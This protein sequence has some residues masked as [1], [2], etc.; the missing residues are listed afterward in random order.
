MDLRCC[1]GELQKKCIGLHGRSLCLCEGL[2]LQCFPPLRACGRFIPR[3]SDWCLQQWRSWEKSFSPFEGGRWS[4]DQFT[5][6][7]HDVGLASAEHAMCISCLWQIHG[8][9]LSSWVKKKQLL[10]GNPNGQ[11]RVLV[12]PQAYTGE[13]AEVIFTMYLD[14]GGVE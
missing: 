1:P 12:G 10:G 3:C 7:I 5:D 14:V 13:M 2:G 9:K 6:S 8:R 11:G 4:R